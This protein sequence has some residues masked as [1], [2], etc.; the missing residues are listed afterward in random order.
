MDKIGALIWVPESGD[1]EFARKTCA[2]V[3]NEVNASGGI[4][5]KNIF[6]QLEI[7]PDDNDPY[8][9]QDQFSEKIKQTPDLI[10]GHLRGAPGLKSLEKLKT[11]SSKSHLFFTSFDIAWNLT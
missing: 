3:E 11:L 8:A 5:G 10:F 9:D 2:L 1:I 7:M 6:L 4:A